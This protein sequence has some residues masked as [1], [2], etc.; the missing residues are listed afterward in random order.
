M[1]VRLGDLV[2]LKKQIG[3][4]SPQEIWLVIGWNGFNDYIRVQSVNTGEVCQYNLALLEHLKR[5][6]ICK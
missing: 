4:S 3:R 6:K 5:E 1:L 2:C